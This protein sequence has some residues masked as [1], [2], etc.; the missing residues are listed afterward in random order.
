MPSLLKTHLVPG[1]RLQPMQKQH[2]N[3]DE[4]RSAVTVVNIDIQHTG[5]SDSS[6][7]NCAVYFTVTMTT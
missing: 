3:M 5:A 2:G 7:F 6:Q 1:D 4:N